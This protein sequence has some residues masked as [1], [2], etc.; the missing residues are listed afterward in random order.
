MNLP[1][2][3]ALAAL[4]ALP[5]FVAATP[6]HAVDAG[7]GSPC[8]SFDFSG[9]LDCKI[10]V[11]GGCS[12]NCSSLKFEAA[13]TGGCTATPVDAG[14][15]S[16]CVDPCG[17]QCVKQCDPAHL[18]CFVGCH[19]E[20]D[21]PTVAECKQSTPNADCVSEAKAHCD[22]HCKESCK[23]PPS[24]CEEHCNRCCTGSCTTQVNYSCD[25]KCFADVKGGCDVH[26]AK[27]EGAL[28]CNGQ[29][30]NAGD[31]EACISYLVQ[32]GV[33]VDVSARGSVQCSLQ[34]CAGAGSILPSPGKSAGCATSAGGDTG[35]GV[36]GL[37][38]VGVTAGVVRTRRRRVVREK[39]KSTPSAP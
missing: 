3:H 34:G 16:G 38:A 10:Q 6:A 8:G 32:Q 5:F 17:A 28:F 13:C 1:L 27:P 29:Y 33:S 19:N 18:D 25:T 20:C 14:P 2:R 24:N 37:L 30:V 15:D 23:I 36:L 31:V 35:L 39:S 21:E 26:C 4:V 11:S 9:G 22:M 12:A 7:A